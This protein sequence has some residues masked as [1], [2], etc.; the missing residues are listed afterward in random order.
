M[1]LVESRTVWR[2]ITVKNGHGALGIDVLSYLPAPY[3]VFVLLR[4]GMY[5][6]N[7]D[8]VYENHL[9]LLTENHPELCATHK[10]CHA[11]WPTEPLPRKNQMRAL[12]G[13]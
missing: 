9:P 8:P 1:C 11:P 2:H 4:Q 10:L 13:F 6:P 3:L 12:F 7:Q 5:I